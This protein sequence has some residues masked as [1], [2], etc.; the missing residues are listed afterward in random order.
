M[1]TEKYKV[2]PQERRVVRKLF[3]HVKNLPSLFILTAKGD[4]TPALQ[5][6]SSVS[7]ELSS[8]G[9][10]LQLQRSSIHSVAANGHTVHQKGND[11]TL[12]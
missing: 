9:S 12:N 2:F 8:Q 1:S 7:A 10:R 11:A 3:M 4:R 5:T 6:Q